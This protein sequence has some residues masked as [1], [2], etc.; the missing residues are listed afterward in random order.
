MRNNINKIIE[1]NEG[2]KENNENK[3][4]KKFIIL[5]INFI[6]IFFAYFI[7]FWNLD[8]KGDEKII[9]QKT[10]KEILDKTV[11]VVKNKEISEIQN[12]ISYKLYKVLD[13]DT[14]KIFDKDWEKKSV[15]MI[16]LDTPESYKT[17][18]WYK[19]CF[20]DNASNYLKNIIWNSEFVE[21]ELDKTQWDDWIDRYWRYLWYV[22]LNWENL[23]LKMIKD[24]YWWEYTYR[25]NKY[26]YQKEF[27]RAEDF[28]EEN[29]LGL[30]SNDTCWGKR[31]EIK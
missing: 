1:K 25:W 17:R 23:N 28:A 4:N 20:W 14:I 15:R 31:L 2:N 3:E 21:I 5:L 22:F 16:W 8:L 7:I 24:G 13:W 6:L 9:I 19:E 12:L 29:D 18:F 30:W 27:K 26:K 10:Q 11:E